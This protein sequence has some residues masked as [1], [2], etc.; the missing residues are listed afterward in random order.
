VTEFGKKYMNYDTWDESNVVHVGYGESV[1][2][3]T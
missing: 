2:P 1:L 3:I